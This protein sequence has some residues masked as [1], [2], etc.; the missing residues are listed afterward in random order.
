MTSIRQ[1]LEQTIIG[2]CLLENGYS[3]IA[4]V[5]TSRNFTQ[6]KPISHRV[7]F[8]AIERLYPTRPVDLITIAHEI[9]K[10]GYGTYLAECVAKV[11][12][13]DNLRYHAFILL[14]MN[15]RDALIRTLDKARSAHISTTTHS[16]IQDIVDECLDT[17]N[18]ILEIFPKALT[19]LEATG[20]EES[21]LVEVRTLLHGIEQKAITIRDQAH[22][23]CLVNN[24]NQL[25]NIGTDITSRLALSRL[26][27]LTKGVLIK[28]NVSP[29]VLDALNRVE[30]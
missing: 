18:D 6:S 27:E 4:G 25:S 2:T 26:V 7:I 17:S 29:A 22:I 1:D 30:L 15:M 23:E 11:C 13:S 28:G 21:I 12:S 24:L 14:Q 19:Y 3:R 20:V 16:A 5:I 8:G 9:N 10:P